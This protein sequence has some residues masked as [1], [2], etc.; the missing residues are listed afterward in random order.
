MMEVATRKADVTFFSRVA[1][2]RFMK[3]NPGRLRDITGSEP[4]RVYA[5]CLILPIDDAP[6]RS[7]IDS[8]LSEMIENGVIDEAFRRNGENPEEYYRPAIPY[9][10]PRAD[11]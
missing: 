2:A 6:F 9:R 11:R 1:A 7:M 4:I 10:S 5:E 8:A 3:Q